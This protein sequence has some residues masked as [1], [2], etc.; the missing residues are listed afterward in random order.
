M[1]SHTGEDAIRKILAVTGIGRVNGPYARQNPAHK[2]CWCWTVSR[3]GHLLAFARA[4]R[5][6]TG[7][8][9]SD[10]LDALVLALEKKQGKGRPELSYDEYMAAVFSHLEKIDP[11]PEVDDQEDLDNFEDGQL[12]VPDSEIDAESCCC[13]P[14]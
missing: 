5:P 10:K 1:V 13:P 2:P 14:W 7:T 11:V 8:R 9:T 12:L 6:W 3:L 4:I